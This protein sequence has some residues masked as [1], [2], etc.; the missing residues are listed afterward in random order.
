M[1]LAGIDSGLADEQDKYRLVADTTIGNTT[2]PVTAA[3]QN[4]YPSP[5]GTTPSYASGETNYVVGA[6]LLGAQIAGESQGGTTSAT[7]LDGGT[8]ATTNSSTLS[9]GVATTVNGVAHFRI[10]YP[11]NVN[12]VNTGCTNSS[13]DTR[14]T[15]TGSARVI[16][17]AYVNESVS[18]ISN[19]FCF[20]VV[21]DGSITP[22]VDSIG[23][24]GVTD[25]P[26]EL[27][28]G[29]DEI[30]VPFWNVRASVTL[31]PAAGSGITVQVGSPTDPAS[32]YVVTGSDGWGTV[33]ITV[34]G[35]ISG[36]SATVT[37]RALNTTTDI[38]I[39]I[40]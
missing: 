12:T 18:T 1:V 6:S 13:L 3:Y 11:A 25:I 2:L 15:P 4:V 17:A 38:T 24:N 14:V 27:R 10:T 22:D 19:S 16:L 37:L 32:G 34:S 23:R 21:T 26:F 36:D 29:G 5:S 35:G 31:A 30:A 39:T 33:R 8:T 40:P 28:D 9:A 7:T 20:G